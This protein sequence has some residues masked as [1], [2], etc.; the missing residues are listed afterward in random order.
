[1]SYEI[2]LEKFSGPLRKLLELIESKKYEITEVNLAKVTGDFLEHL[3]TVE[4]GE[5]R[6]LADFISVAAKLILIK[7]KSL[8]PDFELT[9]EE[10]EGIRDLEEK[11]KLY[12]ELKGA[13]EKFA[14]L[15]AK[16]GMS[17]LRDTSLFERNPVFSPSSDLTAMS[18][19]ASISLMREA[20][21][22]LKRQYEEYEMVDF[23]A[24]VSGLISRIGEKITSFD[25]ISGNKEKKEIILLF[26]ALLQLLKD[27]KISVN[28]E[29]S[30][31]KITI[32]SKKWR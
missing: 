12:K 26:L 20:V 8:I 19:F 11:L 31:S 5:P 30:F 24:Y 7:S 13:E 10:E 17:F 3:K 32:K 23:E 29:D 9:P 21:S 22:S 1:M 6:L 4:T 15:W 16:N 27:N 25:S 28:Q 14:S 18:L 2:T